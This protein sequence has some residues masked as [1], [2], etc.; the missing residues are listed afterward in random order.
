MRILK[1]PTGYATGGGAAKINMNEQ[2]HKE[3]KMWCFLREN[4]K[5]ILKVKTV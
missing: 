2:K 5:Y 3:P 4:N 1:N